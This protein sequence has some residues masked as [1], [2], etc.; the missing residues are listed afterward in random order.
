MN[1]L[2]DNIVQN[3]FAGYM[4]SYPHKTAYRNFARPLDLKELWRTSTSKPLTLY[5]HIPFCL[6][7]CGYCN[8]LSTTSF[9]KPQ[10][11]RYVGKMLEE[12]AAVRVFLELDQ[13]K[14][15]I[16]SSV[17]VGGGTPT[18]L[19]DED[20][21]KLLAGIAGILDINFSKTFFSIETSPRTLTKSKLELLK[22]YHVDRISMGVQSFNSRELDQSF[23][24]ESVSE[25]ETALALLFEQQIPIRNLDLIY[26]IPTQTKDSWKNSLEKAIT[27]APD[28]L[29]LYPLYVREKTKMFDRSQCDIR[30]MGELYE[31]GKEVL[32]EHNYLQTSM[33]NFIHRRQTAGLFPEYSCQENEMIGI[34]CGAR[35]YCGRVHYSRSY[36]VDEANINAIINEYLAETNFTAARYGYRLTDDELKRRYIIKSILKITGLDSAEYYARFQTQPADD[37]SELAFLVEHGF[38]EQRNKCLYPTAKGIR[39]SDAIGQLFVSKEVSAKMAAYQE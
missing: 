23:R 24:R 27:Y 21:K 38:L 34:G 13:R 2:L 33:R 31:L 15:R 32:A 7:K 28:E 36:A 8:L 3:R 25:I 16:F 20:L 35:S 19:S 14:D 1:G 10:I 30:L 12:M 18:I 9:G 6:N 11:S 37:F 22:A 4:Y 29:Y 5:L 17:I 39:Y 26:G